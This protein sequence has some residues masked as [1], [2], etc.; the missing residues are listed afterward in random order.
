[1][2]RS[3]GDPAAPGDGR[4]GGQ[5]AQRAEPRGGRR[6]AALATAV[7]V[8]TLSMSLAGAGPRIRV[9]T[10]QITDCV[11]SAEVKVRAA[12]EEMDRARTHRRRD[13]RR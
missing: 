4:A 5:W 2:L 9:L 6:V 10:S 1:M 7:V 13:R 8:L 12:T 3:D 11:L